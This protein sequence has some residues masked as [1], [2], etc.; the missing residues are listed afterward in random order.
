M[1]VHAETMQRRLAVHKLE[2]R[3]GA[4]AVGCAQHKKF[5]PDIDDEKGVRRFGSTWK[6]MSWE[7]DLA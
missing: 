6:R 5:L 4:H 3:E 2:G 7:S 1:K